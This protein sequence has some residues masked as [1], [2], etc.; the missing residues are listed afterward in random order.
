MKERERGSAGR[1]RETKWD[2]RENLKLCNWVGRWES[3]KSKIN[4]IKD[5]ILTVGGFKKEKKLI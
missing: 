5:K 3:D 2:L 4:D 1:D